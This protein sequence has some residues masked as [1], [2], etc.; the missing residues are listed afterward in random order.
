MGM[1]VSKSH[2]HKRQH[3]IRKGAVIWIITDDIMY[4]YIYN[5][6]I[7]IMIYT[8]VYINLTGSVN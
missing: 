3:N 6:N 4:V 8:V 1:P 2:T 7:N 5:I